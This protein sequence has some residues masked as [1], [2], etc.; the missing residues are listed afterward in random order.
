MNFETHTYTVPSH[1]MSALFNG[2]FSGLTNDDINLIDNF[3]YDIENT[4]PDSTYHWS[5][6]DNGSNM[7]YFTAHHDMT[8]LGCLPCDS[9]D[10][11]LNVA[12]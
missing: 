5:H 8:W 1:F 3:I 2:D 10:I 6:N 7:S 11:I 9:T 12:I 4:Y